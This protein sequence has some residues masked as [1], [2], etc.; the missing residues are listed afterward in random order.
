MANF[1]KLVRDRIPEIIKESGRECII[2]VLE[3]HDYLKSLNNKL[4]EELDEYYTDDDITEL[5]DLVEVIYAILK[6]KGISIEE[7]EK[8]RLDKKTKRGGFDKGVFLVST[9]VD[10][11]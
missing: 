8:I 11:K 5:A 7:F 3:D 4:K 6:Y 2:T 1:N 9:F 10:K